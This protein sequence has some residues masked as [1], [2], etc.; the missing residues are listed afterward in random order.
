MRVIEGIRLALKDL[1]AN[2]LRSLLTMLGVIIGVAS[3]IALVSIGQGV[4]IFID[5]QIEALGSNLVIVLPGQQKGITGGTVGGTISTLTLEDAK[6]LQQ[7]SNYIQKVAPVLEA[8]G[9]VNY[10][11][12]M[13]NTIVNGTNSNYDEIRSHEIA[14]GRFLNGKDDKKAS[15]V[16]VLGS[17]VKESLFNAQNPVGKNIILNGEEFQVIGF[18]KPKGQALTIDNDDRIFIP[19]SRAVKLLETD[20]ISLIFAQAADSNSVSKAVSDTK[21][22]IKRLHGKNDFSVSEQQ[23]ILTAFKGITETLTAM[24]AG[25]AGVSLMVGGIGIMNIMLVSVTERTREIGV[26]KAVG[27][28]DSDILAQFLIESVVLS[29]LGGLIGVGLGVLGSQMLDEV[30][31]SLSTAITVNSIVISLVFATLVGLIFGILP[32]LRASRLDPIEAL[33]YE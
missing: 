31:P 22:I 9:Q 17:V 11:D 19:V 32:A 8:G 10:K 4:K 16:V 5:E 6:A 24:L 7:D 33:R 23:D 13:F 15:S 28:K 25:I 21:Q 3:V 26:R 12:Q 18:M 1:Q 20:K 30:I 27:A 14:E 2:K 29:L